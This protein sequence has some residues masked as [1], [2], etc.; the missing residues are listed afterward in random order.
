MQEWAVNSSAMLPTLQAC[1][2]VF[3]HLNVT[4]TIGNSLT[5]HGTEA[6]NPCG[7]RRFCA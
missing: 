4:V 5:M 3:F 7:Y 6:V 1:S 2:L